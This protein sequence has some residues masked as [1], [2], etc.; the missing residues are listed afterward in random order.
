MSKENAV[1]NL[2]KCIE[3]LRQIELKDSSFSR[4]VVLHQLMNDV[5]DE[6]TLQIFI[7]KINNWI[8]KYHRN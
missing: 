2:L 3:D 7:V 1:E 5:L 8:N 6:Y 4:A